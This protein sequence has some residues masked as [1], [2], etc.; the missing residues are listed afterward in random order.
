MNRSRDAGGGRGSASGRADGSDPKSAAAL[1]DPGSAAA[2]LDPRSAVA[3]LDRGS[4]TDARTCAA[5][6][7]TAMAGWARAG[8]C[9]AMA[10]SMLTGVD[11]SRSIFQPPSGWR[12]ST[13]LS[14]QWKRD[15]SPPTWRTARLM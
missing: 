1:L 14:I 11:C 5:V 9:S 7:G 6:R 3:L 12:L 2:P 4:P 8:Q 10:P 15:S 13:A